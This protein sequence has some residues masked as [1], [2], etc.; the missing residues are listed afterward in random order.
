LVILAL[1]SQVVSLAPALVLVIILGY[2]A[3][4]HQSLFMAIFMLLTAFEST[5]DFTPTLGMS[6]SGFS[7][8]PEDLFM[9]IGA[10]AALARIGQWRLRWIT[11]MPVLV[12]AVL[13][14]LGIITWI[15]TFGIKLGTNSWRDQMLIVSILL[16]TTTRPRAWFWKD[17]QVII[18]MPAIVVAVASLAGGM[19]HGFGSSSSAVEIG[20]LIEGGR[21]VSAS[22]SLL[23]LV[24]LWV[25]VLSVAKWSANRVLVVLLMGSMVLLT[26]NR[27]VWIAAILGIVVWWLVPRIRPRGT[28]GGLSGLSRTIVILI[29]AT[30]VAFVGASLAAL[31]QSASNNGT[32]LWRIA[33][34][35]DSMNIARSGLQWLVGSAFGPTPASTPKLFATTAHSV[36]VD[37]IEMTGFIGL[38]AVLFLVIAVG[39]AQL[40]PS[41]EP[42]GL[43]ASLTFLSFG[44]AYQLPAW[45]YMV[46]GILLASTPTKRRT[47]SWPTT[48]HTELDLTGSATAGKR[49]ID[50]VRS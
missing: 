44:V 22:G 33:R 25:T 23:M 50:R 29:F 27:S 35:T 7:V 16:Y 1:F 14:G 6:V 36:Y 10:G 37:S 41:I 38:A 30:A 20:G 18:V 32:W 46:T 49:D 12:M 21:P 3:V 42:V 5:R 2:I 47:D 43:I 31:G 28:S 34:W 39:R 8:Y 48:R 45:A 26:Q 11:R 15:W 19:L 4:R 24:G 40:P 9:A 17:L 13:L